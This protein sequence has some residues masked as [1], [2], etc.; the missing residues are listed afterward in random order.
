MFWARVKAV[1]QV[2]EQNIKNKCP[3]EKNQ[4]NATMM[5]GIERLWL[6]V[7]KLNG[8]NYKTVFKYS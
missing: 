2:F 7:A 8:Y 3:R 1:H 5:H 6:F 4:L